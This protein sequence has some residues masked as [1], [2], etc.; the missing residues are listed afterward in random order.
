MGESFV[1]RVLVDLTL[2]E[3][4]KS[5]EKIAPEKLN[6]YRNMILVDSNRPLDTVDQSISL[7]LDEIEK[8]QKKVQK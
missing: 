5:V 3:R 1:H 4:Q 6:I 7:L 8:T 2:K